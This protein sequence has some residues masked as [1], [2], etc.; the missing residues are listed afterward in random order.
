MLLIGARSPARTD[1]SGDLVTLAR[2]DRFA[3]GR[4]LGQVWLLPPAPVDRRPTSSRRGTA[5]PASPR[6]TPSPPPTR[7]P[8]GT[9]SWS[10]TTGCWRLAPSPVVRLNRA[11]CGRQG[12]RPRAGPAGARGSGER[13]SAS[14]TYFLLGAVTAQL[15]WEQGDL[16]RARQCLER[17]LEQPCTAPERRALERRLGRRPSWPV[18]RT[19]VT[20]VSRVWPLEE[21]ALS[22]STSGSRWRRRRSTARRR[23][24]RRAARTSSPPRRC[25]RSRRRD[26]RP[27]RP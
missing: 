5:R 2:Q 14:R 13:P 12:A 11:V 3:L 7:R 24:T 23:T 20:P 16:E 19:L 21:P 6:S 17:A 26:T 15:L 9:R 1:Q 10:S 25:R 27:Q 22:R 4:P 8:T 18:A